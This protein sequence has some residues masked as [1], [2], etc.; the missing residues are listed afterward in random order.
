MCGICG[1]AAH[2]TQANANDPAR[3]AL[4]QRMLAKLQHRGPQGSGVATSRGAV[5]G[6]CRLA[7]R[8]PSEGQQPL[9]SAE[10]V[11]AVC[12]GEIDNHAELR[13]WLAGRQRS[14]P[15]ASDVSVIIPLYRELGPQFVERLEGTFALAL[16]DPRS[17]QLLLARDRAGE[18]SLFFAVR[19]GEVRFASEL[20]ALAASEAGDFVPNGAAIRVYLQDGCFLDG[21][22]AFADVHKVR[23]GEVV[24]LAGGNIN[25]T[26]YWRWP[27]VSAVKQPPSLDAFDRIF[28]RAV[29]RQSAAD[30]P[31]GVFVSGGLDSTLIAAV[32][33]KLHPTRRISA[34]T[35]R[36]RE[37]SYDEGIFAARASKLL[38]LDLVD[39]DVDPRSFV[40]SMERLVR[41]TGEPLADPA[42]AA[43]AL[44]AQRAGQELRLVLSG[45]GA[46]EL[47]GGY[48]TYI[49]AN[50]GDAYSRLPPTIRNVVRRVV[51]AWPHSDRKVPVAYLLQRLVS[52]DG[53]RGLARH[54]QWNAFVSLPELRALGLEPPSA[55]A[56][57][58]QGELLDLVQR[59]DFEAGLGEGFLT[60]ADRGGMSA[61]VEI[62]APFLDLGVLEFAA[63]LPLKQRARGTATKRFLKRYALTYLPHDVVHRRKRG[64]SV[65]LASWM[66]GSLHN[67]IRDRLESDRLTDAGI[68]GRAAKRLLDEHRLGRANHARAL[69]TLAVLDQWLEW[70]RDRVADAVE[71]N[72][73]AQ[74]EL[75]L[76]VSVS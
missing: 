63:T 52:T 23:P 10:G 43:T 47:F 31:F 41:L 65:P 30:V 69:W 48:P 13:Q 4:V 26:Q 34:F 22:S 57:E 68:D 51:D 39:V 53:A 76:R 74:P 21:A 18:H 70:N 37:A 6:A 1:V 54:R 2:L 35:L 72:A 45:E 49:G 73:I 25:R 42:W 3:G 27:I 44:L 75:H 58:E 71:R 17:A 40:D 16:W 36:F 5:F 61:A 24:L 56:A 7:I 67:W 50:L 66:R 8:A 46:D 14:V 12:N 11:L 28:T 20:G 15:G 55:P 59:Y 62:R 38:D 32:A 60:K 9:W 33:R 19:S 29:S 64:L